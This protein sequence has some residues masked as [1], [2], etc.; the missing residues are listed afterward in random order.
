MIDKN[1][2][3]G[4]INKKR[5]KSKPDANP[6][7]T[8]D[9]VKIVFEKAPT[10]IR[11]ALGVMLATGLDPSDALELPKEAIQDGVVWDWRNKTS[12]EQAVPVGPLLEAIIQGIEPHEAPTLLANSRGASWTYSGVAA[13]WHTFRQRMVEAGH[14]VKPLTLKALRHTLATSLRE[15]GIDER[16]IA[17]VLGQKTPAMARHYSRNAALAK[18]NKKT[19]KSILKREQALAKVVKPSPKSVK[20]N[21]QKE[22]GE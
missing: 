15:E 4:V 3:S 7:W 16:S 8:L 19:M 20:P 18:K 17:D 6:P 2:A 5:P 10:H 21:N 13:S 11:S 22:S 1:Y 14:P 9:Q 12:H